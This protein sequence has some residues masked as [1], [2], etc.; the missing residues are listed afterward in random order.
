VIGVAISNLV[1]VIVK[2]RQGHHTNPVDLA[3]SADSHRTQAR[4]LTRMGKGLAF[5]VKE[6]VISRVSKATDSREHDLKGLVGFRNVN[7]SNDLPLAQGIQ[8]G[9]SL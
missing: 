7:Y 4:R 6:A 2:K 3:R 9:D 5:S 1:G 8:F